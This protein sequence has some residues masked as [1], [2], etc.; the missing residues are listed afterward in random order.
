[1][2]LLAWLFNAVVFVC[3]VIVIIK[4]FQT[5]GILQG[6]L[7]LICPIWAFIWG[8]MNS[9]RVGKN[10]MLAWTICWILAVVFGV[11]S[12]LSGSLTGGRY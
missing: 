11:S 7:G 3:W 2:I 8:W 1:M 12:G 6:I 10:L 4:M 9:E 5:A